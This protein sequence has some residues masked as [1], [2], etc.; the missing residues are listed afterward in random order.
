M[1][2]NERLSLLALI[3]ALLALIIALG[4]LVQQIFGTADG[5]RRCQ[6]SVIGPWSKYTKLRWRWSQFRFETKFATPDIRLMNIELG[7]GY[8]DLFARQS[9]IPERSSTDP[10]GDQETAVSWV[11]LLFEIRAKERW[12]TQGE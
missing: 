7:S 8:L 3:V 10:S 6:E 1:D 5:Y 9:H 4:Q 2:E 12:K 11:N